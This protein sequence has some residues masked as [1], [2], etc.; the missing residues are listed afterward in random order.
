[1]SCFKRR[2]SYLRSLS[3]GVCQSGLSSNEHIKN[4]P[5]NTPSSPLISSLSSNKKIAE[6]SNEG[7][8]MM[9]PACF[10]PCHALRSSRELRASSVEIAGISQYK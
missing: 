1:M 2:F 3:S 7:Y 8:M 5:D 6:G 4:T 10:K 9:S